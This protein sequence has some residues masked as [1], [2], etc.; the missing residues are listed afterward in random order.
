MIGRKLQ[1]NVRQLHELATGCLL[2]D[3][4]KVF[5]PQHLLQKSGKLTDEEY[6]LIKEHATMGYELL[7][8]SLPIM[9]TYV[10]Y[11]HHERQGGSGYPRGLTGSNAIKRDDSGNQI[12]LYGEILA[13]ADMYDALSS[14]HP[15]R[16]SLLHDKVLDII[17]NSAY[18]HLNAEIVN[19]FLSIVPKYPVGSNCEIASGK[20]AGYQGVVISLNEGP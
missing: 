10:A 2:H 7:K 9:P 1:L 13:V 20:F 17:K 4:G 14:D 19:A 11:Q 12:A 6:E 8:E 3:I 5:I 18:S 15:Y 16:K